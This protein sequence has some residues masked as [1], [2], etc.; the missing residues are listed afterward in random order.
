VAL[1]LVRLERLERLV[2]R[3]VLALLVA[4]REAHTQE[5]FL[6]CLLLDLARKRQCFRHRLASLACLG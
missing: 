4:Q 1:R 2:R 6:G 3:V 5:R